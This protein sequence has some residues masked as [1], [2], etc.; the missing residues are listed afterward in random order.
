MS[1]Q[2]KS[3]AEDILRRN[4]VRPD[5]P[6]GKA[7]L[8]VIPEDVGLMVLGND[9]NEIAAKLDTQ[10]Q[11]RDAELEPEQKRF[12]LALAATALHF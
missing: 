6:Q 3:L 2:V 5:S 11:K 7:C 1:V 12:L 8:Q 4:G 10:R 9:N